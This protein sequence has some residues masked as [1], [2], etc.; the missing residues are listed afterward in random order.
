MAATF[1]NAHVP[2]VI[3]GEKSVR[4][5][6]EVGQ[7]GANLSHVGLLHEQKGHAGPEEDD[8]RLGVAGQGFA[9]EVFF[10][11]GDVVVGQPVILER[12]DVLDSQEDVVVAEI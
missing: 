2:V 8:A 10:P 9:L 5:L 6:G 11:E 12:L 7:G 3:Y 1:G 4:H